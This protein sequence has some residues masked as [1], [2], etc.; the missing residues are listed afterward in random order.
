M[1]LPSAIHAAELL[2]AATLIPIHY[3][4]RAI[5][6]LLTAQLTSANELEA[7]LPSVPQLEI[8]VLPPGRPATLRPK[9]PS[10]PL[11]PKGV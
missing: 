9:A 7:V 2:G 10:P 3:T 8:A 4:Q 5:R 1:D 6:P 11:G